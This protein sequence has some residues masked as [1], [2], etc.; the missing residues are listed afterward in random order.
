MDNQDNTVRAQLENKSL[1]GERI[2][3]AYLVTGILGAGGM[4]NVY[5]ARQEA[6]GR[7]V[8]IK[9]LPLE[10]AQDEVAVQRLAR[11]AKTLGQLNHPGIVTTYDF[12]F[13]AG[14]EPYIVLELVEGNTLHKILEKEKYL[15]AAR[16][17]P[18]F[19]QICEAMSYAHNHGLVH[20]DLKPANL[21][22]GVRDG[23]EFVKILDFGIVKLTRESQQITKAGEIW[24]SPYYMS[25]EQC[26]GGIVDNRSDI[27]GLG[28]VMYRTLCAA[29][30]HQGASFA[31]TI[32]HKLHQEAPPFAEI[33]PHLEIL[34]ELE[35][36]V[37]KCLDIN[38]DERFPSMQ[39]LRAELLKL[40]RARIDYE[41]THSYS[42]LPGTAANEAAV[43][44]ASRG[45]A[46]GSTSG[47]T[48]PGG[49]LSTG[50]NTKNTGAQSSPAVRKPVARQN[51]ASSGSG[52]KTVL[53]VLACVALAI[54]GV[55]FGV[56]CL[57]ESK[58]HPSSVV[59]PKQKIDTA[60]GGAPQQSEEAKSGELSKNTSVPESDTKPARKVINAVKE[61]LKEARPARLETSP[62]TSPET[63]KEVRKEA[64]KEVRK[65]VSKEARKEVSKEVR[66]AARNAVRKVRVNS[67]EDPQPFHSRHSL[68]DDPNRFY[69]DYSGH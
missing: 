64:R 28:V 27:Y 23:V 44:Q 58:L 54:G 3:N 38:P 66:K 57:I 48:R 2:A 16:A 56:Y 34:P 26:T 17:V 1:V 68:S 61:E 19:I 10:L 6:M 14:G 45:G 29:L 40:F 12:G 4:G 46:S 65:E 50:S 55:A 62:E 60:G 31:E 21:I 41:S 8:A 67:A 15:G 22:V 37:L 32:A 20:R 39:K 47:S 59:E 24:G 43:L 35:A 9:I 53:I 25:P 52:D 33:A 18:L 36:I 13:T 63:S 30:P 5:R 69:R 42:D 49:A 11:E 51:K 7:D